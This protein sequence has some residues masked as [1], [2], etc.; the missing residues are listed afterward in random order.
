[1]TDRVDL[2]VQQFVEAWRLMCQGG[3]R[4]D[5][6]AAGGVQ[7]TFS[8]CP[9]PFFNVALPTGRDISADTL[10]A[11]GRHAC[12]WAATRNVPWLFVVTHEALDAGTDAAAVLDDCGL[13]SLMP[14]TGMLADHVAPP[15]N[16]PSELDLTMPED[17]A[18]CAA[19]LDVNGL[20]YGM[21]LGAAKEAIGTRGF[22]KDHFPVLGLTAGK[23]ASTAS[24][25]MVDGY[26]YV[27][28]VATDPQQQRRGYAD[29]AM[30]RALELAAQAHGER[31]T[32][33]HSSDAGRP[34]YERM[35]YD[36]ISTH[37]VFMEKR[38]L[39]AH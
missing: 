1:M 38:F 17:D 15:T 26:R 32:V 7:Y 20:A 18:G 27:A 28:L 35:G 39:D 11:Q 8:G 37:T 31:P 3:P 33:L 34:V 36:V 14:L 12:G 16:I 19:I 2:S 22:W 25:M 23:P 13:G 5:D 29:A 4:Y 10:R 9:I 6:A 30:R 24:V 21:E